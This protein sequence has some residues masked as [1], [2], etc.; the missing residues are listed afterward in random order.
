M[1]FFF[2]SLW[3][4]SW[5]TQLVSEKITWYGGNLHTVGDQ[6]WTSVCKGD[7]GG[8]LT[9]GKEN[10]ENWVFLYSRNPLRLFFPSSHTLI[11]IAIFSSHL[12]LEDNLNVFF[13]VFPLLLRSLPW[14]SSVLSSMIKA[15]TFLSQYSYYLCISILS[16]TKIHYLIT[17]IKSKQ[18]WWGCREI[19][20]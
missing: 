19:F 16:I 10:G 20:L 9:D 4:Y 13:L 7:R 17:I 14:L 1:N 18:R 15:F 6:R 5:L 3:K 11:S 12:L 2:I 8:R